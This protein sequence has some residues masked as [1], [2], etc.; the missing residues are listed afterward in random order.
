[1]SSSV[2]SVVKLVRHRLEPDEPAPRLSQ[3]FPSQASGAW[4][5]WATSV[6]GCKTILAPSKA[7]PPAAAP[8][9]SD[10]EHPFLRS[11]SPLATF[12][13]QP[14]S[15]NMSWIFSFSIGRS[16]G[17][18]HSWGSSLASFDPAELYGCHGR[19]RPGRRATSA[20]EIERIVGLRGSVGLLIE[21][22]EYLV[23]QRGQHAQA[24]LIAPEREAVMMVP[25]EDR[26]GEADQWCSGIALKILSVGVTDQEIDRLGKQQRAHVPEILAG[27]HLAVA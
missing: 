19:I 5:K 16:L 7:Q 24:T 23:E 12:L 26:E 15:L 20:R 18:S 2:R 17:R 11:A 1:M 10:F 27:P 13:S 22:V 9:V 21:F 8:G 14:G 3:E 6:I 4:I 25:V